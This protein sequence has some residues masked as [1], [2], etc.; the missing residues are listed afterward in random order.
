M[1]LW[2]LWYASRRSRERITPGHREDSGPRRSE[3][4]EASAAKR[5][6]VEARSERAALRCGARRRSELAGELRRPTRFYRRAPPTTMLCCKWPQAEPA[7]ESVGEDS[8]APF[9]RS[10]AARGW[11][12]S[13][14]TTRSSCT[15]APPDHPRRDPHADRAVDDVHPGVDQGLDRGYSY[16]RTGNLTVMALENK[17]AELEGRH[18][19][20]SARGW[21]RRSPSSATMKAGDHCVITNCSYGGTNRACRTMFTD[22]GHGVRLH[23]F[24]GHETSSRT[25]S[26]TRSSSSQ[27]RPPTRPS[28]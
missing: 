15:R 24:H 16:A 28:L 4:A 17:I 2:S 23:R 14:S 1:P 7:A 20:A 25:S 12:R 9:A 26:R 5:H 8:A 21:R 27:S 19:A 10:R 18:G 11:R 13:P 22:E 6:V 3:A